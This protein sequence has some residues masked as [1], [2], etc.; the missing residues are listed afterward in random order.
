M[1]CGMCV[2]LC[3]LLLAKRVCRSR[4]CVL[5]PCVLLLGDCLCVLLMGKLLSVYYLWTGYVWADRFHSDCFL[6]GFLFDVLCRP[7]AVG[8]CPCGLLLGEFPCG[9]FMIGLPIYALRLGELLLSELAYRPRPVWLFQC[10]LLLD[11]RLCGLVL[12]GLLLGA[13]LRCVLPYNL[14]HTNRTTP[15]TPT[16]NCTYPQLLAIDAATAVAYVS[17]HV[18]NRSHACFCLLK[19]TCVYY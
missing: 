13:L 7:L 2:L 15:S 8:P 18:R 17:R 3:E 11:E 9:L 10:R 1:W 5:S 19:P 14:S 12:I 6:C 16:H 4:S